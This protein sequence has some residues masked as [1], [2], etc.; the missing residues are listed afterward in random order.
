MI[1]YFKA[2]SFEVD[3]WNFASSYFTYYFHDHLEDVVHGKS[4]RSPKKKKMTGLL[5]FDLKTYLDLLSELKE[6]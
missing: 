6:D 3:L 5:A 1:L 4:L 2:I